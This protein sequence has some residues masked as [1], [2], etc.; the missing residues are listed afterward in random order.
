MSQS[1]ALVETLKKL[2]KAKGVTYR[3]LARKLSLSEASVKRI[4]SQHTFTLERLDEVCAL[5]GIDFQELARLSRPEA[6]DESLTLNYEQESALAQDPKLFAYFY[7]VLTEHKPS[8]IHRA[9]RFSDAEG[10]RHLV[11]LDKLGLIKLHP[12]NRVQLLV[13]RN[14]RW[15]A[16][17]PLDTL[18]ADEIKSEFIQS[19]FTAT[20]ERLRLL[21]GYLSERSLKTLSLRIDKVVSHFLDASDMDA[22][23]GDKH[24]QKIWFMLAYRPWNFSVVSK[25][26]R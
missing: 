11:K 5:L 3:D 7:L 13:S 15:L 1:R 12:S 4:F 21:S 6:Q 14:V 17:G 20:N 2:M 19:E 25:L 26:K 9:Y 22:R 16:K 24:C 10:T 8:D 23:S 18:Y